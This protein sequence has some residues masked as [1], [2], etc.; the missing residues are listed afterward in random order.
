MTRKILYGAL[1]LTLIALG[2]TTTA[3]AFDL[4]SAF[5]EPCTGG[6]GILADI[7][8]A[9]N[10]LHDFVHEQEIR[11]N[12]LNAT[13]IV[14]Q[15]QINSLNSTQIAEISEQNLM[16][17]NATTS[18]TN[19]G[20]LQGNVTSLENTK[21]DTSRMVFTVATDSDSTP[22]EQSSAPVDGWC[23][24]GLSLNSFKITDSAVSDSSYVLA[25]VDGQTGSSF[26]CFVTNVDSGF[27]TVSCVSVIADGAELYYIVME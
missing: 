21:F 14:Q 27:F 8:N 13:Q 15:T 19:I 12:S 7:C 26:G 18:R 6:M 2:S 4:P 1:V 9:I 17:V 16:Q 24:N 11:T 3:Q 5:D 25:H 10:D 23:P 22:C 20:I